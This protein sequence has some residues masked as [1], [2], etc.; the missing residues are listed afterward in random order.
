MSNSVQKQIKDNPV[1]KQVKDIQEQNY[2][3]LQQLSIIVLLLQVTLFVIH[4]FGSI[5]AARPGLLHLP[6][7]SWM[8]LDYGIILVMVSFVFLLGI[9]WYFWRLQNEPQFHVLFIE[10]KEEE[11]IDAKRFLTPLL[12]PVCISI[13]LAFPML[14]YELYPGYWWSSEQPLSWTL[15]H[16][17]FPY[18]P[19]I[20][21]V[22]LSAVFYFAYRITPE[23]LKRGV[24]WLLLIPILLSIGTELHKISFNVLAWYALALNSKAPL[25]GSIKVTADI[26]LFGASALFLASLFVLLYLIYDNNP[27]NKNFSTFVDEGHLQGVIDEGVWILPERV[28]KDDTY[29]SSLDVTLSD[30]FIT[31]ASSENN[32]YKSN[33]H[34]EAEIK[35]IGLDVGGAERLRISESSSSLPTTT[36]IFSFKQSGVHTIHL[37]INVIS[38]PDQSRDVV[39][40]H[41]HTV[42]VDSFLSISSKPVL[43]FIMPIILT[44]MRGLLGK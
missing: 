10:R 34:L 17:L 23:R 24:T 22:C 14:G 41:E 11:Q 43:A 38:L 33:D 15:E 5:V 8:K 6:D 31:K 16:T 9:V 35:A 40:M 1:R 12:I 25:P 28:R 36:W 26:L 29:G 19:L 4:W 2:K 42:K 32:P 20:V 13:G 21:V 7:A 27:E 44:V 18:Y 30:K 3:I 37:K 39:F